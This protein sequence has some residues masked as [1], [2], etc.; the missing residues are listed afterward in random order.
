MLLF[1]GFLLLVLCFC[2][3]LWYN[4][5]NTCIGGFLMLRW[6][7]GGFPHKGWKHVDVEDLAKDISPGERIKYAQCEM[8]GNEKIRFVHIL[9][10]PEFDGELRVGCSCASKLTDDYVN[11]QQRER[12]LKNRLKRSENFA[13][14]DW[15]VNPYSGNVVISYKGE[16]ITIIKSKYGNYGIAYHNKY[17]WKY[18]GKNIY[19]IETAKQA[20]FEL[21]DQYRS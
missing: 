11:P 1:V 9:T 7:K 17:F 8:C 13:K 3:M 21:F 10:H 6:N 20:A 2:G 19:D 16:R 4:E 15:S 14:Q 18:R 12:D 5:I